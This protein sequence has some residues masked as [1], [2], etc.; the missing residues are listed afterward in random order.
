MSEPA[1]TGAT[2][3]PGATPGQPAATT[4]PPAGATPPAPSPATPPATGD[5]G[6]GDAGKRALT[7][8]RE[9]RAAAEARAK[10][11]E[12]ERDAL[13]TAGLSDQDKALSDAKRTATSERDAHWK[14]RIRAVEV[15][16]ALRGAGAVNAEI[17]ELALSA[18]QFR[19]LKVD[20]ETGA[21]E[22]LEAAVESF[23]AAVPQA[24]GTATTQPGPGGA[25]GGSE[26]G[27]GR[28]EPVTLSEAI[29]DHYANP[30]PR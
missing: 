12:E 2:P 10:A 30:K 24:F 6:L 18:R 7:A 9:A 22:G 29:A 19:D 23:K 5:D 3:G 17:I 26:G 4:T 27:S 21:V 1:G 28:R 20:A 16:G 25:W 15:R 14:A 11:A 13:R 8:E